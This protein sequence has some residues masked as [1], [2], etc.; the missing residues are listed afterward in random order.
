MTVP[1]IIFSLAVSF[2][3]NSSVMSHWF[4]RPHCDFIYNTYPENLLY[5]LQQANEKTTSAA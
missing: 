5:N 1:Y 4:M 2:I 3:P